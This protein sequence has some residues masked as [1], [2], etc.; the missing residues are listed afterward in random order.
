MSELVWR[1]IVI[2]IGATILMDLWALL[3]SCFPGQRRPDWAPAGRWFWH[4]GHGQV[5]HDDIGRSPAYAHEEALGWIGHYLV[6]ALYG[7]ILVLL[8]GPGWLAHPTFWPAWIWGIVTIAAGWFLLLPGMGLG[9]AGAATPAPGR[10]RLLGLIAHTVFGF[11]LFAT[12][13]L[14]CDCARA[15]PARAIGTAVDEENSMPRNAVLI[16][17]GSAALLSACADEHLKTYRADHKAFLKELIYCENNYAS[18]RDTPACRAAFQ[19][20]SEL[21]PG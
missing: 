5:F 2:G 6:G 11:G 18:Q 8:M 21:F 7:V 3:L 19:V 13:L 14:V 16:L 10:T 4:L 17:L 12:A 20:N 15:D 9:W 1:G